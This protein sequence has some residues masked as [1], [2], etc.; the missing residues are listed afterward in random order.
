MDVSKKKEETAAERSARLDGEERE[1]LY[2]ARYD[3]MGPL[4]RADE[5][6]SADDYRAAV[7]LYGSALV[8]CSEPT[9]RRSVLKRRAYANLK[10][11]E[12]S[13]ELEAP[14]AATAA[15][16]AK[17]RADAD[18]MIEDD[19]NGADGYGLRASISAEDED[20]L[21]G[22]IRDYGRAA[23]LSTGEDR[24]DF[25]ESKRAAEDAR[26]SRD[27]RRKTLRKA[28]E[29][30]KAAADG[31][32]RAKDYAGA[33]AAYGDALRRAAAPEDQATLRSNRCAASLKIGDNAAALADATAIV[34]LRPA[35]AKGHA[36]LGASYRALGG[37][38]NAA[39]A[40]A[41]FA[42]GLAL[43][44]A[45]DELYRGVEDALRVEVGSAASAQLK[46]RG[47]A[48]FRDGDAGTAAAAYSLALATDRGN[49]KL[50]SNRSAAFAKL[51]HHKKAFG[52][53]RTCVGLQPKWVK[54][55]RRCGDALL[56]MRN[57]EHA[58][59]YY[60]KACALA[61]SDSGASQAR[62]ECL[63][64]LVKEDGLQAVKRRALFK[65]DAKLKSNAVRIWACS[66]VHYDHAGAPE[67]AENLSDTAYQRDCLVL[68]GDIADTLYGVKLCLQ[69]FRKKFRRVFYVPGN[70]DL[71]I[72]PGLNDDEVAK[73]P[74]SIAKFVAMHALCDEIGCEMTPAEVCA[75]VFVV[76]TYGWYSPTYDHH[77]PKPGSV[78]FDK[79][80]KWPVDHNE[81]WK[82]FHAWNEPRIALLHKEPYAKPKSKKQ[83]DLVTFGH[84]LP[85]KELPYP[86]QI[87]EFAKCAGLAELDTQIRALG[88]KLHVFGHTHM[89]TWHTLDGVGYVQNAIGYG[90]SNSTQFQLV[91]DGNRVTC[92]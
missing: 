57:V 10:L 29:D 26:R 59:W 19:A 69:A 66:D 24:H 27:A 48:A 90:C 22:A 6:F 73:F 45:S 82:I 36:R 53:A 62:L 23:M 71:W 25:E 33:V 91:Y 64:K 61:P 31:K 21:E 38:A 17:A 58:Y 18:A 55:Y 37:N 88:A 12:R 9:E 68:A 49:E 34:G 83:R 8:G 76:P 67:W 3:A 51:G 74:D 85:R 16:V 75:G 72:R 44:P 78:R 39:R 7:D 35:W 84:F 63:K 52:D 14:A 80:A 92:H 56:S 54:G 4:A 46:A 32:F 13:K 47:D 65:R 79:Y 50:W 60:A 20:A 70:H 40:R 89:N 86:G 43:E 5:A 81:A 41:A 28:H 87:H 2:Q 11:A 77:D 15:L 42:A 30:L 1:R